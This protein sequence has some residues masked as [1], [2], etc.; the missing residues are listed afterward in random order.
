[1]DT[2]LKAVCVCVCIYIY[3]YIYIRITVSRTYIIGSKE[4]PFL[5]LTRKGMNINAIPHIHPEV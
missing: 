4:G 3:I 2:L 1:M 5:L